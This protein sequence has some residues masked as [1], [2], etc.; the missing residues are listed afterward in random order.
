MQPKR[1]SQRSALAVIAVAG[2][3]CACGGRATADAPGPRDA[4][5]SDAS[6]ASDVQPSPEASLV[7][8]RSDATTTTD[9]APTAF[10]EGGAKAFWQGTYVEP[11]AVTSG[12]V[13]MDCCDGFTVHWHTASALGFDAVFRLSVPGPM[14]EGTYDLSDASGPPVTVS[15]A[16]GPSTNDQTLE[17]TL[18]ILQPGGPD[19]PSHLGICVSVTAPGDPL[20]GLRLYVPDARL[21]SWAQQELW[22]LHPLADGQMSAVEAAKLPLDSL[23]L[24]PS[25]ANLLQVAY[26]DASD[27]AIVWDTWGSTPMILNQLPD[28][29]VGGVPFVVRVDGQSVFLGAFMTSFSSMSFHGP[30]VT[31]EHVVDDRLVL[32]P[33]YPGGPAPNP[34]PRNDPRILKAFE[35]AGKLVP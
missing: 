22:T 1:L 18:T 29:G 11:V 3:L 7:D 31:V 34:D 12:L 17:G 23:A 27:Y 20:D 13:V 30:T 4:G 14:P 5:A 24:G 28:V 21:A 33:G 35:D 9:A 19:E 10:C 16:G 25:L 2:M 6:A 8:A 15:K 32:E 26:Y